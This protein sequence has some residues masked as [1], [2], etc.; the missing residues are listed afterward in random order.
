[1]D[2][3][4]FPCGASGAVWEWFQWGVVGRLAGVDG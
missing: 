4:G 3:G 1:M 2:R